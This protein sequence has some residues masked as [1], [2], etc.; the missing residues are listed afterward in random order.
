M[1]LRDEVRDALKEFIVR[2]CEK[3]SLTDDHVRVI[4]MYLDRYGAH[5]TRPSRIEQ[6][7]GQ[8]E[9]EKESFVPKSEPFP[10][11]GLVT[12]EQAAKHLGLGDYKHPAS[13]MRR[14]SNEGKIAPP[15][16]R[17]SRAWRYS[18]ED[19][20]RYKQELGTERGAA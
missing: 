11:D 7:M 12:A 18:A 14:L 6:Y 8:M 16:R 10:F 9:H 4:E 1:P 5:Q 15:V 2:A 20:R 19:I 13:I 17:G 3:D